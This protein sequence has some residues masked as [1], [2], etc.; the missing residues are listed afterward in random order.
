MEAIESPVKI[1]FLE[2]VT[3]APSECYSV[4]KVDKRFADT[5]KHTRVQASETS[6]FR[7]VTVL[8]VNQ[9]QV[10]S[11]PQKMGSQS[12]VQELT[13]SFNN[14]G[15]TSVEEMNYIDSTVYG[16]GST[17]KADEDTP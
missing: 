15:T 14:D 12:Y 3:N 6:N 8:G 11:G 7:S 5:Q 4:A 17:L 13:N 16:D 2:K 1:N 10:L 9:H